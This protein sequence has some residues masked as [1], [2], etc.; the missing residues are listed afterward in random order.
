[1]WIVNGILYLLGLLLLLLLL[2]I[3]VISIAF[4]VIVVGLFIENIKDKEGVFHRIVEVLN[5]W[6]W[7]W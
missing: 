6:Y 4:I 1:M 7:Y 2:C 5:N 3:F